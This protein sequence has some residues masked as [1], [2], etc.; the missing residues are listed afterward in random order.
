MLNPTFIVNPGGS[1]G[2]A[3]GDKVIEYNDQ[4]KL[5]L[6][7]KVGNPTYPPETFVK[8]TII[9]F[10]ITQEGLEEQMLSRLVSL[11]NPSLE[12]RKVEIITKN[13]DD[14]LKLF[15]IEDSIL[16]SLSASSSSISDLLRDETLINEL[17][18]SKKFFQEINRRMDES[19][20]TEK[21]LDLTREQYR[22]VALFA[23]T[24]YFTILSLSSIEYMYQWSMDWFGNLVDLATNQAEKHQVVKDR[25]RAVRQRIME[26]VYDRV[27]RTL[28]E[29]HKLLLSLILL[30]A[31]M[32]S[33]S[34]LDDKGR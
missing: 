27:C 8:T 10:S 20:I 25:V 16:N 4:F 11:E 31:V 19:R 33:N 18:N 28:Y 15:Q 12:V 32:R 34:T 22:D 29:K 2:M 30:T 5:M 9:N 24:C 1:K 7:T 13:A 26:L 6:A 23:S 3:L 21:H 17:Q 14:Q